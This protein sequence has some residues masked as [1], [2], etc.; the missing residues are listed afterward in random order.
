MAG[1]LNTALSGLRIS[2]TALRATGHNIANANTDG[3]SRQRVDIETNN[4]SFS[5]AGYIGNGAHVESVE[6]IANQFV[7]DQLRIDSSLTG[8]LSAFNENIRQLD[9]MLSDPAT[10]LSN[11]LDSFFATLQYGADDPTSIPAR[12]LIISEAENLAT[13]FHTLY[14]RFES[15]NEGVNQ[16]LEASVSQ[17]NALS[18]NIA[19]LN[20]SIAAAMGLSDS[21]PNDLLDQRDNALR[22]LAS[23]VSIQVIEQNDGKV[24]VSVG[25]GQA[26]VVGSDVRRLK[27]VEGD[28]DPSQ[29]D[30]A[31]DDGGKEQIITRFLT[32]G[33]VGGLTSFRDTA[34]NDAYNELGRVALV[35]ADTFNEAHRLGLDLNS[36]FGGRF[37]ADIN[38]PQLALSRVFPS[39]SNAPPSDGVLSLE[40]SD[41][42]LITSSD[43]ELNITSNNIYRVTRIS[44]GVEVAAGGLPG[45]LPASIAFD[46]FELNLISGSFQVGDKFII[47]PTRTASRDIAV[48]ISRPE[49]LA[50]AS[51]L[52][53]EASL[54][55]IGDGSIS[56]GEVLSLEGIGGSTLPLFATPGQMSPPLIVQFTS[57]TTYDILDNSDPGNPQPLDPPIRNRQYIPGVI[58][59]LFAS[60]PG[61]TIILS[62][63]DLATTALGLASATAGGNGYPAETISFSTF[64]P[65]TGSS[66]ISSVTTVAGASAR[67]TAALLAA[68]AGVSASAHN[69]I[70]LS[71]MNLTPAP[72]S[73]EINLNGTSFVADA[74]T[75]GDMTSEA[76]VYDYLAQQINQDAGF[77]SQ[78]IYA[79]SGTDASGNRELRIYDSNGDDLSIGLVAG[80]DVNLNDELG[81]PAVTL[82][83]GDTRVVGGYIDVTLADRVSMNTTPTVSALFGDSSA[84]GF[85]QSTYLGIQASISGNP[86]TGD[87]FTLDFNQ[88]GITDNRN[89]LRMGNL[90]LGKFVDEGRSTYSEAYAALVEGVGIK[91]SASNINLKASEQVLQQT[92]DLRDSISGVNLDE[93]A[94]SLIK[95]EQVYNANAQVISVARD[96][97][98]RLINVF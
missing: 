97:F 6:R 32:G 12:Q 33:E 30:I 51:P 38:D 20:T 5:G 43:Y 19:E 15:L 21:P 69:Y 17:I 77:Q 78:G 71:G 57:P 7:I 90:G 45:A 50:F 63:D 16:K 25:S 24:N 96:L 74:T 58:N 48:E 56:P 9:S 55:N 93:E 79:V 84:A 54:G 31:Y 46:G 37:F 1:I 81:N 89:A 40:I 3:Y 98:D 42:S 8:E 35:M 10:G 44:D 83:A 64:D 28:E 65:I 66:S 59:N 86:V 11:S 41:S 92:S 47:Q 26:L 72:A 76:Q 87:S 39:S 18:A 80:P 61:E 67:E 88:D 60:D 82:S 13:R 4:A 68:E 23:L 73:V 53:T 27:L 62:N 94:A 95:F 2:Q 14:E 36:D 34:L 70:D 29:M 75:V 22:E 49:D 91:T 52:S 85:A